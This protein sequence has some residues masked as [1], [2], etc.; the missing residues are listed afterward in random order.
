MLQAINAGS[1]CCAKA[2]SSIRSLPLAVLQCP[3]YQNEKARRALPFAAGFPLVAY[4]RYYRGDR[5]L[6]HQIDVGS[7]PA[8]SPSLAGSQR[9][10]G[11]EA[12]DPLTSDKFSLSTTLKALSREVYRPG[13]FSF[14]AAAASAGATLDAS[15]SLGSRS[16]L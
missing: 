14:P 2:A 13:G 8:L 9:I 11:R 1:D 12:A 10:G 3:S 16:L 15:I 7:P 6:F 4:L 5:S